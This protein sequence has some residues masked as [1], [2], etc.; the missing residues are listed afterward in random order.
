MSLL[1][2]QFTGIGH[3]ERTGICHKCETTDEVEKMV[4]EYVNE[5]APVAQ[6][7]RGIDFKSQKV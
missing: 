6:L 1:T 5:N 3:N 4:A 2:L 7:G